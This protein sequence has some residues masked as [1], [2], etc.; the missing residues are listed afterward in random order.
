MHNVLVLTDSTGGGR[1][2]GRDGGRDRGREGRKGEYLVISIYISLSLSHCLLHEAT[3]E[4]STVDGSYSLQLP[5]ANPRQGTHC[6][7]GNN[8]THHHDNKHLNVRVNMWNKD[9][10]KIIQ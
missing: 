3:M 4:Y 6:H 2:R 10:W 8:N 7:Y 9:G 5:S 1:E